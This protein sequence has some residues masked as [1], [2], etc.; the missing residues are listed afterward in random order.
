[1]IKIRKK[2]DGEER[3]KHRALKVVDSGL[4]IRRRRFDGDRMKSGKRV[5]KLCSLQTT[6]FHKEKITFIIN[7][8]QVV[9]FNRRGGFVFLFFFFNILY[10]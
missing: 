8:D 9:D 2:K 6:S 7:F 1:M 4:H 10:K 5:V 3:D